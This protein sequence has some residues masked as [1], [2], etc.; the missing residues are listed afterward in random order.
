MKIKSTNPRFTKGLELNENILSGDTYGAREKI[1]TYWDGKWD[2]ERKVWIVNPAKV[3]ATLNSKYNWGLEIGSDDT[4]TNETTTARV[5]NGLCPH[6]H[7]YC[8]GDCQSH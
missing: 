1:K 3:I 7:T 2:A 4:T 8:Y 5:N 6:C